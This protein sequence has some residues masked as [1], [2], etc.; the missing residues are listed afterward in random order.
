MSPILARTKSSLI[1]IF[2]ALCKFVFS[3]FLWYCIFQKKRWLCHRR[4][5]LF[6]DCTRFT[7][8]CCAVISE[9][10]KSELKITI[11]FV[12]LKLEA[13]QH[14]SLTIPS[15]SFHSMYHIYIYLHSINLLLCRYIYQLVTIE[16]SRFFWMNSKDEL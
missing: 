8:R 10:S 15:L 13:R 3:Y 1:F 9:W 12:A 4:S 14:L 7:I 16:V 2:V 5:P 11:N 6:V